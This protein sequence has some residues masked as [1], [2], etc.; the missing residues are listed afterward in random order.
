[1][2]QLVKDAA[3]GSLDTMQ[4]IRRIFIESLHLNLRE[5]DFSYEAKLD[6]AAGLG[7][8]AVAQEHLEQRV[9]A[10]F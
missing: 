10:A 6:E 9:E 8:V 1:M 5:E 2:E 3:S 4:R 7:S